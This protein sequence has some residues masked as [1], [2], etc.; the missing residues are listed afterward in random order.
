[1]SAK[2]ISLR[3]E[4]YDRILASYKITISQLNDGIQAAQSTDTPPDQL[5]QM[6]EQLLREKLCYGEILR[7][8]QILFNTP[9][10]EE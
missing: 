2:E 7:Q 5:R 4:H 9:W 3:L 10:T 8:I 6:E 1:M